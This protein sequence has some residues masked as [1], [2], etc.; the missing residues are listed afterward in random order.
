MPEFGLGCLFDDPSNP[1][2]VTVF[3]PET[4]RLRTEWLTADRSTAVA[5]ES[6]R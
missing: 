3:S 2:T 1:S 4:D 6:V 5:L